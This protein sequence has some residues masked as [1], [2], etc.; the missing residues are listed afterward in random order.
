MKFEVFHGGMSALTVAADNED[1][2]WKKL[3]LAG[4]RNRSGLLN[5][6]RVE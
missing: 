1:E 6:V 3:R 4:I 5:I 2:V